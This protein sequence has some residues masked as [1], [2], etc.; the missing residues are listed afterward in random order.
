MDVTC[1]GDRFRVTGDVLLVATGRIPNGDLLELDASGIRHDHG[2]VLVDDAQRTNVEGVW[3]FGDVSNE[4]QLK[5]LAN[6][7]AKV[8]AHNILHP[9]DLRHIDASLTPHAVFGLPQV[10]SVG[11]TERDAIERGIPHVAVRRDYSSTAYGWA[12]EDTDGFA[13]LVVHAHDRTVLG[14]HIIGPQAPT[15]LQQLVQG[16]ALGSTVDD[17]AHAFMYVHPALPELTENVL[18]EAISALDGRRA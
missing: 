9:D 6:L 2:R 3:A 17:M 15:L 12:M 7:E 16:M 5:H 18:L 11:V 14:A 1:E 8:V 13:K 4:L 10:A